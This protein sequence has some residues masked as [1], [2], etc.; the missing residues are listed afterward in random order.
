MRLADVLGPNARG[1]A[2]D[3]VV[4]FFGD[5][6]QICVV[7]WF[8][9]DHRPKNLLA[10]DLHRRL[11]VGE[12]GWLDEVAPVAARFFPAGRNL[13]TLIDAR[14]DI[15]RDALKLFF[16]NERPHVGRWIE[17]RPHLDFLGRCRHAL[18]DLVE[19]VFVRI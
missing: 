17:P 15:G 10:D 19:D 7:E 11:R 12:D 4:R 13:R 14:L 8:S 1:E 5:P 18:D 16:G 3:R 9:T 2:V 6:L